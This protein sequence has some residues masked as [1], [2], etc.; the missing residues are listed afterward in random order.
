MRELHVRTVHQ[1]KR[2]IQ[3]FSPRPPRGATYMLQLLVDVL[4]GA[5]AAKVRRLLYSFSEVLH[6]VLPPPF[7]LHT[8]PDQMQEL[9]QSLR[10]NRV[11]PSCQRGKGMLTCTI[12]AGKA[13]QYSNT[14]RKRH[15]F[16]FYEHL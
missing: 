15:N 7:P 10:K 16:T 5:L 14:A 1:P 3:R 2:P 13:M 8:L 9:L 6:T 4:L 12:D 11:L